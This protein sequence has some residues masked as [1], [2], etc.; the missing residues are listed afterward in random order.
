MESTQQ[1]LKGIL[2]KN[3]KY[4]YYQAS[5]FNYMKGMED[6]ENPKIQPAKNPD[7]EIL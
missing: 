2:A 7:S 6:W 4:K 1:H 5:T 3:I